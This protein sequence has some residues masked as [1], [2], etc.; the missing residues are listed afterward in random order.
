MSESFFQKLASRFRAVGD[1][2]DPPPM[3]DLHCHL[4]PGVDDG[5][6]DW[7][8]TLEMCRIAQQDG[9]RQ[10]VATPHANHQF[11]YSREQHETAVEELRGKFKDL[12]VITGC[13]FHCSYENVQD[14]L[15]HPHRYTIGNTRY[16]LLE[17]NDFATARQMTDTM[18][19]ITGAGFRSIITHPE[20][21]ALASQSS[22]FGRVL[23]DAGGLLQITAN[24]LTGY[25]GSRV[26]KISE[27][28]LKSGLVAIIA[29]DAH[30]T[31]RRTPVLSEA[32]RVS[33]QLVGPEHASELV[34]G[35]PRAILLD[36]EVYADRR[37]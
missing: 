15:A 37:T 2:P 4:L 11:P 8:T 20:R 17:F 5:P 19:V 22:D 24:S 13:D 23:V 28:L 14:A 12:E 35:N 33:S 7:E 36:Q 3:V 18:A 10:I 21:M 26:Q 9:I 30:E 34:A 29:S 31:T 27:R 32:W 25:W 6:K 16:L 1:T